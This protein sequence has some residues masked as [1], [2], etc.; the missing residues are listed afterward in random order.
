MVVRIVYKPIVRHD[1]VWQTSQLATAKKPIDI[2]TDLK[3]KY[4]NIIKRLN[5]LIYYY[6]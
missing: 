4:I 6:C 1:S 2:N 3:Q 5:I